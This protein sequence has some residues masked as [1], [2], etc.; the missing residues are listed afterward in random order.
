MTSSS[1]PALSPRNP[2]AGNPYLYSYSLAGVVDDDLGNHGISS[3]YAH[4]TPPAPLPEYLDPQSRPS[5]PWSR[6]TAR[7]SAAP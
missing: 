1:A 6:K 4:R 3:I 2:A 7:N 5:P